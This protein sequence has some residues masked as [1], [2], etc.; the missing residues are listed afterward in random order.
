MDINDALD[1]LPDDDAVI[2]HRA[3]A[4]TMLDQIAQRAR[5]ALAEHGID[6]SVFF[7]VPSSGQM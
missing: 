2:A 4:A 7:L 3:R 1:D 5:Q 6:L